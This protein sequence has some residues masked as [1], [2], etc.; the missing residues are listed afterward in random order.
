MVPRHPVPKYRQHSYK[1]SSSSKRLAAIKAYLAFK[2]WLELRWIRI[3][4][5]AAQHA[6]AAAA[7]RAWMRKLWHAHDDSGED[8]IELQSLVGRSADRQSRPRLSI[9]S[10]AAAHAAGGSGFKNKKG[11]MHARAATKVCS[12]SRPGLRGSRTSEG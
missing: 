8:S 4:D 7:P 6:A 10:P 1:A 5:L 11:V 9:P 2:K 12:N 3:A